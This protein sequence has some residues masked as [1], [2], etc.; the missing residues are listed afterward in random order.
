MSTNDITQVSTVHDTVA[1]LSKTKEILNDDIFTLD[2]NTQSHTQ[3][4]RMN[5]S[6]DMEQI[7]LCPDQTLSLI[8]QQILQAQRLQDVEMQHINNTSAQPVTSDI[9]GINSTYNSDSNTQSWLTN[10]LQGFDKK[11]RSNI[12]THLQKRDH[13]WQHVAS[14]LE[15]Q[16]SRMNNMEQQMNQLSELRVCV[17][18]TQTQITKQNTDLSEL[19][20]KMNEYDRSINHYSDMCNN[21][22]RTSADSY[23]KINYLLKKV[24]TLVI[25]QAQIQS[26]AAVY[27]EKVV[28]LQCRS[29]RQNLIFTGISE[30]ELPVGEYE[31]VNYTLR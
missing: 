27:E 3:S 9:L 16:S 13:W 29:M 31:D 5:Q 26:Q 1:I 23:S 19:S 8:E 21:I 17:S 30:P 10:V 24:E 7:A 12:E 2:H 28:D 22:V 25:N 6:R 11:K 14:Q 20:A 4:K 15:H 18:I